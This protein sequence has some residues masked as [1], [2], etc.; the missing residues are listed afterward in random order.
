MALS[1]SFLRVSKKC[2]GQQHG[3]LFQS[4]TGVSLERWAHTPCL[5]VLPKRHMSRAKPVI[6]YDI[7][8]PDFD[9]Q[10]YDKEGAFSPAVIKFMESRFLENDGGKEAIVTNFTEGSPLGIIQLNDFVFGANPRIDIIHRVMVWQRACMRAGTACVKNRAQVRGGGRKP[11]PQKGTGR[12]RQGSIRAPHY[13]KGGVVHGPIPRSY[14]YALPSKVQRMGLRAIMSCRYAQGDLFVV[15]N[16]D[17]LSPFEEDML[18]ILK[19]RGWTK[20]TLVDGFENETL[21]T[22]TYNMPKVMVN[23]CLDIN[24][25]DIVNTDKLVLS[26]EAVEFIENRLCEDNRIITDPFY[27][28]HTTRPSTEKELQEV[29]EERFN[30]S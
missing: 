8:K 16:F 2:L 5:S 11:R 9:V 7:E 18:P 12:S 14:E 3:L 23:N 26:L 17:S 24:V 21:K 22:A 19:S 6:R 20:A 28:F 1:R 30:E 25:L 13:R 29:Y 4:T 27:H 10:K 15:E